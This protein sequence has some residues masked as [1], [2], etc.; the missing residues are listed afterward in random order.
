[1]STKTIIKNE[2]I[3]TAAIEGNSIRLIR[4]RLDTGVE[5]SNSIIYETEHKSLV[6]MDVN[7]DDNGTVLIV[8]GA[9]VIATFPVEN[10]TAYDV[11]P[12]NNPTSANPTAA[13]LIPMGSI[14]DGKEW[15]RL[16]VEGNPTMHWGW[17]K[18]YL[19]T[20]QGLV[21]GSVGT[22]RAWREDP[23]TPGGSVPGVPPTVFSIKMLPASQNN[24]SVFA[25]KS[26]NGVQTF[27]FGNGTGT[28]SYYYDETAFRT[29]FE[30]TYATAVLTK[31][32]S[33]YKG[34]EAKANL[35]TTLYGE[36]GPAGG[37]M[38]TQNGLYKTSVNYLLETVCP[39]EY[40]GEAAKLFS[41][42]DYAFNL[43]SGTIIFQGTNLK[44]KGAHVGLHRGSIGEVKEIVSNT[45][46]AKF[47]VVENGNVFN[48][49]SIFSTDLNVFSISKESLA[50]EKS[51]SGLAPN[52]YSLRDILP[53]E[54][55]S[56]IW[57]VGVDALS[58]HAAVVTYASV[59][60][61]PDSSMN[62]SNG[63]SVGS[64]SCVNGATYLCV[65]SD[66]T[67]SKW[68]KITSAIHDMTVLPSLAHNESS[69]YKSGDFSVYRGVIYF[70]VSSSNKS[71]A[72]VQISGGTNKY[73]ATSNPTNSDDAHLGYAKGSL[74]FTS[75][76]V[77]YC[78]S[79]LV[80]S[81]VWVK[82]SAITLADKLV[83]PSVTD[84]TYDEGTIWVTEEG[85]VYICT[86]KAT[87]ASVWVN[88]S[89]NDSSIEADVSMTSTLVDSITATAFSSG[90]FLFEGTMWLWVSSVS[91]VTF[92][93]GVDA[94]TVVAYADF[95]C[96]I[97]VANGKLFLLFVT[98]THDNAYLKTATMVGG[99]LTTITTRTP[100]FGYF[101]TKIDGAQ[102]SYFR[103][104][105]RVYS[106]GGKIL[107][108]LP[109]H[110]SQSMYLGNTLTYTYVDYTGAVISSAQTAN[111]V[112]AVSSYSKGRVIYS[113]YYAA[114][115]YGSTSTLVTYVF[116]GT[117]R[118][119]LPTQSALT[120][121]SDMFTDVDFF[122]D[123]A[124]ASGV[125]TVPLSKISIAPTDK[126]F[127]IAFG[128]YGKF[129]IYEYDYDS[130]TGAILGEVETDIPISYS[131]VL[132]KKGAAYCLKQQASVISFSG[133][134][135]GG[136]VFSYNGG[137]Y[138]CLEN[139]SDVPG[140]SAAWETVSVGVHSSL[141]KFGVS[142]TAVVKEKL[143]SNYTAEVV[144]GS[145]VS[146]SNS[147]DP[148]VE[149]SIFTSDTVTSIVSDT[150]YDVIPAS[151]PLYGYFVRLV[152]NEGYFIKDGVLIP[153]GKNEVVYGERAPG[154]GDTLYE[155]GSLWYYGSDCY[156]FYS[157]SWHKVGGSSV[158][159]SS[160]NP[161]VNDDELDGHTVGVHWVNGTSIFICVD[162][163]VGSAVWVSIAQGSLKHTV[164]NFNRIGLNKNIGLVTF[165]GMGGVTVSILPDLIRQ[166]ADT[167]IFYIKY[168]T[169]IYKLSGNFVYEEEYD[170]SGISF[171]DFEFSDA[172]R[173]KLWRV[174]S[175][176]Q[177]ATKQSVQAGG[178]LSSW[179]N[180]YAYSFSILGSKLSQSGYTA[181]TLWNSDQSKVQLFAVN[182][183]ADI[184]EDTSLGNIAL[185]TEF[186]PVV[187]GTSLGK[188]ALFAYKSFTSTPPDSRI[189]FYATGGFTN[190][191]SYVDLLNWAD[192]IPVAGAANSAD[193]KF[194]LAF[195]NVSKIVEVNTDRSYVEYD[196]SFT[197]VSIQL[198]V[199]KRA[200]G[201]SFLH[202]LYTDSNRVLHQAVLE[203]GEIR[204]KGELTQ[205][206]G[207]IGDCLV[208]VNY[209]NTS[210]G[211]LDIIVKLESVDSSLLFQTDLS[212]RYVTPAK[213]DDST[214]GYS[215]GSIYGEYICISSSVGDA[216]WKRFYYA[217]L[218]SE[219][220]SSIGNTYK[221]WSSSLN[222][223]EGEFVLYAGV[224]WRCKTNNIN[225]Q[226]QDGS[227]WDAFTEKYLD[228][229]G[230]TTDTW[231]VS[232]ANPMLTTVSNIWNH[233]IDGGLVGVSK[234][235]VGTSVEVAY[236]GNTFVSPTLTTYNVS[237]VN[238]ASAFGFK[239]G[240]K[241]L[242]CSITG[243]SYRHV[244]FILS[245]STVVV[246]TNT[247]FPNNPSGFF[248]QGNHLYFYLNGATTTF[249]CY[250]SSGVY[251]G[252]SSYA[253]GSGWSFRDNPIV[254]SHPNTGAGDLA[255]IVT[256]KIYGTSYRRDVLIKLNP[257]GAPFAATFV[258]EVEGDSG[259]PYTLFGLNAG[260]GAFFGRHVG[261]YQG[262]MQGAITEYIDAGNGTCTE[263]SVWDAIGTHVYG[264]NLSL[265][266]TPY[267]Q[268]KSFV[269][270]S[271]DGQTIKSMK[272]VTYIGSSAALLGDVQIKI[273]ASTTSYILLSISDSQL[274][275]VLFTNSSVNN[276]LYVD[277]TK[278]QKVNES[279]AGLG[280]GDISKISSSV[281]R[282]GLG[283]ESKEIAL[284]ES[285][286]TE[287]R[288][289]EFYK[290]N[291][292][293]YY[294][295]KLY[296]SLTYTEGATPGNSSVWKALS[297]NF[298]KSASD[299]TV[300][301]N[302]A[303]G[304]PVGTFWY[305]TGSAKLFIHNGSGVWVSCF[306]DSYTDST[307]SPS[308]TSDVNS[309][310]KVGSIW[311]WP[312]GYWLCVSN[313]AG[314]A[315]WSYVPKD[316]Q[317]TSPAV[318][319]VTHAGSEWEHLY[320]GTNGTTFYTVGTLVLNN[321][322]D[323]S[324][325]VYECTGAETRRDWFEYSD[326]AQWKYI[327]PA[328]S[329]IKQGTRSAFG[330][331][332]VYFPL[333]RITPFRSVNFLQ[334]YSDTNMVSY[335]N[336]TPPA[337]TSTL[338][339]GLEILA[340]S[341]DDK[342]VFF[343]VK[344]GSGYDWLAVGGLEEIA[345]LT[346]VRP[347]GTLRKRGVRIWRAKGRGNG[348]G[349]TEFGITTTHMEK[350]LSEPRDINEYP[351]H[352]LNE[353]GDRVYL[354]D[355][356]SG[357][358][359]F[360]REV[361]LYGSSV[362]YDPKNYSTWTAGKTDI[363]LITGYNRGD[364]VLLNRRLRVANT[365]NPSVA[366]ADWL[367]YGVLMGA[368]ESDPFEILLGPGYMTY[369]LNQY[370]NLEYD[371]TAEDGYVS[372]YL[373]HEYGGYESYTIWFHQGD[374]LQNGHVVHSGVIPG[375]QY[376]GGYLL[377]AAYTVHDMP[378]NQGV[379]Y[380]LD[381]VKLYDDQDTLLSTITGFYTVVRATLITSS[382]I[383][384][385]GVSGVDR[386][387]VL[388][389]VCSA[390]GT[391]LDEVPLP[392]V[393]SE[394]MLGGIEL[395]NVSSGEVFMSYMKDTTAAGATVHIVRISFDGSSITVS[396]SAHP[397][398]VP[399]GSFKGGV[400]PDNNLGGY[401][402]GTFLRA[403]VPM[404]TDGNYVFF[405]AVA[406]VIDVTLQTSLVVCRVNLDGSSFSA[407]TILS[408][409]SQKKPA[410]VYG[411]TSGIHQADVVRLRYDS[412]QQKLL[413][414][415]TPTQGDSEAANIAQLSNILVL[416]PA[417]LTV[418]KTIEGINGIIS[419]IGEVSPGIFSILT[420]QMEYAY[421]SGL[422]KELWAGDNKLKFSQ[423]GT[424]GR[425][426]QVVSGTF[427]AGD[428]YD[429]GY[430]YQNPYTLDMEVYTF[431]ITASGLE[432]N[433]VPVP[434]AV[435]DDLSKGY[436]PS[437]T[438][439]SSVGNATHIYK[440]LRA[441]IGSAIWQKIPLT[442]L[443]EWNV[444]IPYGRDE[445]ISYKGC[446][447]RSIDLGNIGNIPA[448]SASN[449][450]L[451]LVEA[452]SYK[453]GDDGSLVNPSGNV[454]TPANL[455]IGSGATD[456]VFLYTGG[457]A[458]ITSG[459]SGSQD[460][461]SSYGSTS[462][463]GEVRFKPVDGAWSDFASDSNNGLV[464][465]NFGG[466]YG[467]FD[468]YYLMS[469]YMTAFLGTTLD[470]VIAKNKDVYAGSIAPGNLVVTHDG[471][472]G[473][474]GT[475]KT[476]IVTVAPTSG[477][478]YGDVWYIVD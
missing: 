36:I 207:T 92:S 364:L 8:F 173:I 71:A 315:I 163:T 270:V 175:Q 269:D 252:T 128:Y 351:K 255:F 345:N 443:T 188:N 223:T 243:Q 253:A 328:S 242:V 346:D 333:G 260:V 56:S 441:D 11:A 121:I 448:V 166:I 305:S 272:T 9:E 323:G 294:S 191:P 104:M 83:A 46:P 460:I 371:A 226:P 205:A 284:S 442:G 307:K 43:V 401:H 230:D 16:T 359:S 251:L 54:D 373:K 79:S 184:T 335:F 189:V 317:K 325:N 3:Y 84:D 17:D 435:T 286:V 34:S 81:A 398:Y 50:L 30:G 47:E 140:T 261:S 264:Q 220:V 414:G 372:W 137:W 239:D 141:F 267:T 416:S 74:W 463:Y 347:E 142:T 67:G 37:G 308:V 119:D 58:T 310:Y 319:W 133:T 135:I 130:A 129:T 321:L 25:D 415:Y 383:L 116:D 428:Y 225:Q 115:L 234:L 169:T 247:D 82:V 65:F 215:T 2:V 241:V 190:A 153:N 237:G 233:L 379:F 332:E 470:V 445:I 390:T 412:L 51:G 453:F 431:L 459:A 218:I 101:G 375:T 330:M 73:G 378:K 406:G 228:I 109:C 244:T 440:C 292:V 358:V 327:G 314:A 334:T 265:V 478:S 423:G 291:R 316:L 355:Y 465:F 171:F 85:V 150:L 274:K 156:I 405:A 454:D 93:N 356:D 458:W 476:S 268:F 384:L 120:E 177:W 162:A 185:A 427:T 227:Y 271:L 72:W 49:F 145:L 203:D 374:I 63:Y 186:V 94:D 21:P 474:K 41:G 59:E 149:F 165:K 410:K 40:I 99:S 5:I 197:Y 196:F 143:V 180:R 213:Q 245:G 360:Y 418:E 318:A 455:V 434:P 296:V 217:D 229:S 298:V 282:L 457:E 249:W 157:Q 164:S 136:W 421:Y 300:M 144:E 60:K 380:P 303:D 198:V 172:D 393:G 139:T 461:F 176:L 281:V 148:G 125:Y 170:V 87:G 350:L 88:V 280:L 232:N 295:Q 402:Q 159:T 98:A 240:K 329:Y 114:T 376:T 283:T 399:L 68:V 103:D 29:A 354:L 154:L 160:S 277:I 385:V 273:G 417:T 248:V 429:Y 388:L 35:V 444:A 276:T 216:F 219:A 446:L 28:P 194:F 472:V 167:N 413:I 201:E 464:R 475:P 394:T 179:S 132:Y 275:A 278:S 224:T 146:N 425:G 210:T 77:Y 214:L 64:T 131:S 477:G 91:G 61:Y 127:A 235:T 426:V 386:D 353:A 451:M 126:G 408:H 147:V 468:Y 313:T 106:V 62:L 107:L 311:I 250:T 424:T 204:Y 362:I 420:T 285:T 26:F 293:V 377:Y 192:A 7:V 10:F 290:S 438:L 18:F 403:S 118:V 387:T 449:W 304:Y 343:K 151:F 13:N 174:N 15:V 396:D 108:I 221:E 39:D 365:H 450:A 382:D 322:A 22:V 366:D 100:L 90:S 111:L 1:M 222:Y 246:T 432:L 279:L 263:R 289:D 52:I 200:T 211:N 342:F 202:I 183:G 80:G 357:N 44:V 462:S 193:G 397:V 32:G 287:W 97:T 168:G 407:T 122:W 155:N 134:G 341:A 14:E 102:L 391:T 76:S 23:I 38:V 86:V 208:S 258:Y 297:D 161:T 254:F 187:D 257:N 466:V 395:L 301:E 42:T 178:V 306:V 456:G 48:L 181:L 70:C 20:A 53:S 422:V 320:T 69:G 404:A 6:N 66:S 78:S 473:P 430:G 266:N 24:W 324:W 400:V 212:E 370:N 95:L 409:T 336:G 4:K 326:A 361:K 195:S 57:F 236:Y 113:G 206:V 259:N 302:E 117:G 437:S 89:Q 152:S 31:N 467:Y 452:S 439:V 182:N 123:V 389:R 209:F 433:N 381:G 288:A 231:S 349:F 363:A 392:G 75:S 411:G 368:L 105:I 369:I 331:G 436:T 45:Q 19:T 309:G 124:F 447:Y 339:K 262:A 110:S 471:I 348:G 27:D 367:T 312:L 340:A 12:L 419:D 33:I 338:D 238:G 96:D 112:H 256:K 352:M 158:F 344:S 469:A 299:P 55:V 337:I 199:L 138:K